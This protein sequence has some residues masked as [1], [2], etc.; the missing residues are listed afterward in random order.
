M[1]RQ[2]VANPTIL[3][4]DTHDLYAG[5]A[6]ADKY[7]TADDKKGGNFTLHHIIPYRYPYFIGYLFDAINQ[8]GVFDTIGKKDE[9]PRT[10]RLLA[11]M[12]LICNALLPKQCKFTGADLTDKAKSPTLGHKFAWMGVNLFTGPTS[13][14]RVDDP[15]SNPEPNMPLSFDPEKWER[16]KAIKP[17]ID[18]M[19]YAFNDNHDA[20][21]TGTTLQVRLFDGQIMSLIRH[22]KSLCCYSA[23]AHPYEKFDWV[24]IDLSD[25][26]EPDYTHSYTKQVKHG[27]TGQVLKTV[28]KAVTVKSIGELKELYRKAEE[29]GAADKFMTYYPMDHRGVK[30]FGAASPD[31]IAL[32]RLRLA[33]E[34][35]PK[36]GMTGNFK[37]Q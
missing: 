1:R 28:H 31:Y 14:V 25:R 4:A 24:I 5:R 3:T 9:D 34:P 33:G 26:D 29:L 16:V 21:C 32:W 11:D 30:A 22:L 18:S 13:S 7:H 36:H 6:A 8:A 20:G 35:K 2:T 17:L 23:D 12:K 27:V 37:F 10:R 19:V 15:G